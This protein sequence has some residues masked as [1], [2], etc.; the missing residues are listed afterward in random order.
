MVRV[1]RASQAE[2]EAAVDAL[3]DGELVA[4]PTETVYG[5]GANASNPAAVRRVF[6]LKGRPPAHP[7]I[8]HI[9][10]RKYLKRWVRDMVPAAEKLAEAFWPGPLTLVLPRAEGVHDVVTGGQDSVAMRIPSHPMARQLLDAFGGGIAA[11]SANR[12]GRLSATRAE[13]VQDEFGDAIKIVLDGGEC[14][15]GLESTIVSC[16]DGVTRLLRPGSITLGQLRTVAGEVQVGADRSTPRVPG[17][18]AAHY[19]PATP[20]TLVPGGE[21]DALADSLS[22]GGQRIAVLAQRLPLK[23][24]QF[25]TWI[26]S[27][28]RAESFGHDLYSNLRTLD[29]AG[30]ARILVQE[31]P[32]DERWDAIRDR[33][34]RAS[35]AISQGDDSPAAG[36]LP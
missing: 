5:L 28:T 15:V 34:V 14:Q 12:Y 17:S 7:V 22:E 20:L 6:E 21:L 36:V 24:Y 29:K 13:H 16:L 10:Q 9:D 25:V 23:T 2:L 30:C 11:P 8:V 4:F 3:R 31:V 18:T 35:A 33:L 1:V 19:A 32:S 27:G 26:N